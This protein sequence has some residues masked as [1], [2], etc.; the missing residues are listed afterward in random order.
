MMA[1]AASI[2]AAATCPSLLPAAP[3]LHGSASVSEGILFQHSPIP[4]NKRSYNLIQNPIYCSASK[5][6][7]SGGGCPFFK[8]P[9][10]LTAGRNQAEHTKSPVV[11]AP[12]QG[13]A[14]PGSASSNGNP[15]GSVAMPAIATATVDT[16]PARIVLNEAQPPLSKA[17]AILEPQPV[18]PDRP[19][20]DRQLF[21]RVVNLEDYPGALAEA[22]AFVHKCHAYAE[23]L[24]ENEDWLEGNEEFRRF[25]YS[26][27]ALDQRLAD[28]YTT[29]MEKANEYDPATHPAND[30]SGL[31]VFK[32]RA[33]CDERIVQFTPFNITDG[34]WLSGVHNTSGPVDQVQ[35]LLLHILQDEL[36]NGDPTKNHCNIW[37]DLCHQEGFYPYPHTSQE[38]AND[39]RFLDSAFTMPAYQASISRHTPEFFPEILGI[40]MQFEWFAGPDL[41]TT[42]KLLDYYGVNSH[43]YVMHKGIDNASDGHGAWAVE[44]VKLYLEQVEAQ[45]GYDA[46]QAAWRRIW[47]GLEEQALAPVEPRRTDDAN[48]HAQGPLREPEPRR[49]QAGAHQDQRGVLPPD[50]TD[51]RKLL[52]ELA[53]SPFVDPGSPKTSSIFDLMNFQTGPMLGVFTPAE[54]VLWADWISSLGPQPNPLPP[55][56]AAESFKKALEYFRKQA[57]GEEAHTTKFLHGKGNPQEKEVTEW[58]KGSLDDFMAALAD[59]SNGYVTPHYADASS[60]LT[61]YLAPGGGSMGQFWQNIV[62][63]TGMTGHHIAEAWITA[64]CPLVGDP[65]VASAAVPAEAVR[66][67]LWLSSSAETVRAHPQGKI[68]G[69][70]AVQ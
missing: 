26:E 10:M 36:G 70:G 57:L 67:K 23:A 59:P 34:I 39:P 18:F 13:A 52:D 6:A 43:F 66:T 28:I 30:W 11:S 24:L 15:H 51:P 20:Y 48:D 12:K 56:S 47:N 31:N 19:G 61:V 25:V 21:H 44:A 46:M 16:A 38:F 68:F 54:Q 37:K 60:F 17:G 35:S 41:T 42:I 65:P 53:S 40:T 7:G 32:S 9:S 55:P 64:G 4:N 3:F 2:L 33:D 45:L 69:M 8:Y 1:A 29:H 63:G 49:R 62:P 50:N 14:G 22:K 27:A 58:L 5:G